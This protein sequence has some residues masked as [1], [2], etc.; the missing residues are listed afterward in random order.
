MQVEAG[1]RWLVAL[2][3]RRGDEAQAARLGDRLIAQAG[4]DPDL[5]R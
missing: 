3:M 4:A 5:M 1:A 2:T